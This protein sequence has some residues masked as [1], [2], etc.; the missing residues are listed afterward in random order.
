MMIWL[1]CF[2]HCDGQYSVTE[3]GEKKKQQNQLFS[4]GK[5]LSTVDAFLINF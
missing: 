4:R 1:C 3:E 2:L 5:K